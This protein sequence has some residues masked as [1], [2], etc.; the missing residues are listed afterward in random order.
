MGNVATVVFGVGA[1]AIVGGVVLW[2][3]APDAPAA[4]TA[5]IELVPALGGASVKG[6]W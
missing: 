3:T 6:V 2:A 1:A 5:R 4:T